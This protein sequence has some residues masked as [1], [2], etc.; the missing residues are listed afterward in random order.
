MS[1]SKSAA[2]MLLCAC[3]MFNGSANAFEAAR[4][5]RKNAGSLP[6]NVPE[7][8]LLR[9]AASVLIKIKIAP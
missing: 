3:I 4:D 2:G 7:T 6:P 8:P 5:D 1:K 9:G